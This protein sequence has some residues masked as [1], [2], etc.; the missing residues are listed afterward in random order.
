MSYHYGTLKYFCGCKKLDYYFM[1]EH[2][3]ITNN[4]WIPSLSLNHQWVFTDQMHLSKNLAGKS[5]TL[6]PD[7]NSCRINKVAVSLNKSFRIFE[8]A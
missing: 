5:V 4:T 8:K 6:K 7:P 3:T 1:N 2:W